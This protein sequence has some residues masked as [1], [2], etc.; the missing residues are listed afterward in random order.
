[1]ALK[2]TRFIK[3][4]ILAPDTAALDSVEGELKV[5]SADGKIKV[6]LKDGA[7]PAAAR[8]VITSSQTQ[9]LSNKTLTA[10]VIDTSV[11]GTAIETDLNLSAASNKLATASAIKA[12]VDAQIDTE[13]EADEILTKPSISG[14]V[15][16]SVQDVLEEHEDRLDDLV[17][18][19]GVSANAESLGTFT[20]VTI[21]DS[22]TVKGALQALETAHEEVDQNVNDLVTLSGVA[23]NAT[24]LG[25]FTGA[26]IPDASKVKGALQALETE[27]QAH[28][29]ITGSQVSADVHGIGAGSSVVGTTTNQTLT[30]KTID[31]DNNTISNLEV[32]NLKTGVLNTSTSL[33]GAS[34][35]QVPSALATKTFIESIPASIIVSQSSFTID[36]NSS[37]PITGLIFNPALFRSVKI[38]Y[39]IYRQTDTLGSA[40]AQMGQLRFVYNTQ[41]TEWFVSDD[42]AG[43]NAGVEFSVDSLG[44]VSYLSSDLDPD[45]GNPNYVGVLKYKVIKTFGV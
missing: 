20:G 21:P 25:T 3:G 13:D 28:A 19:S 15:G 36:N 29:G 14:A 44:E 45:N 17:T 2:K 10:P 9:S 26:I 39:S 42:F 33:T 12:Y 18:L 4:I 38:E 34:D 30:T 5:D 31:A 6:T 1:M 24:D 7:N 27:L 23:E 35:T 32:D 40:V 37:S 22:S 11:S 8:E 41:F 43:Q 16:E